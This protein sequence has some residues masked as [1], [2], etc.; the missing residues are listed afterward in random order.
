MISRELIDLI[1]RRYALPREGTHGIL[2]WARVLENGRRLAA[3]TGANV[4]IVELFAVFHDSQRIN[5]GLDDGHGR[6]GAELARDLH[7]LQYGLKDGDL[8]LLIW[9]CE[10]HT[11]GQLKGDI[12]VQTCWDADR[13][14]LGRVGIIPEEEK[15]CTDGARDP[16]LLRWAIKRS[17]ELF[18]PDFVSMD[19]GIGIR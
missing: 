4:R 11:E 18:A 3:V 12:T 19:W 17:E 2:H 7:G 5:E 6:R 16:D 13:L 10:L 14:D 1:L 8:E 15:L 9:A